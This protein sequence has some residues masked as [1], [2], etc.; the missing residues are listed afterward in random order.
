MA[1]IATHRLETTQKDP[2]KKRDPSKPRTQSNHML[3]EKPIHE[4]LI[5]EFSREELFSFHI[6]LVQKLNSLFELHQMKMFP[7]HFLKQYQQNVYGTTP[8]SWFSFLWYFRREQRT[9]G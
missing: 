5:F 9:D 7:N 2:E 4:K 6:E 8:Q 3:T 1:S